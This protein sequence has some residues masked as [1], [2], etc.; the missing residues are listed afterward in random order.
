MAVLDERDALSVEPVYEA[1]FPETLEKFSPG[2]DLSAFHQFGTKEFGRF[3]YR[4]NIVHVVP[5]TAPFVCGQ[6]WIISI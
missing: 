3:I 1:S 6:F 5:M 4:L 2:V